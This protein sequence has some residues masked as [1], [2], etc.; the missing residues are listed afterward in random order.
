M[1][2]TIFSVKEAMR[3]TPPRKM[4]AATAATARPTAI[5]GV[6]KAV[7]KASLSGLGSASTA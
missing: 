3:C 4:K 7:W 5:L 6:P 2:G 1:M